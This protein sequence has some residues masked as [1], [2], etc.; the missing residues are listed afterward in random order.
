MIK[1]SNLS[2]HYYNVV[3]L[4]DI[5]L[6]V[7]RGSVL[8]LLGPNGAGKSTLF[9]LIAGFISPDAGTIEPTSGRWGNIGFKPERLLY[10][11]KMRIG[12]FMKMMAGLS[13]IPANRTKQVV[14]EKLAL[15]G[16]ETFKRKRIKDCSKGMRQR[17]GLAQAML[18]DP[19]LL[20]LDEP[21]NGLDPEGQADIQRLMTALKNAGTT[22]LL[23]SHHLP[24]ITQVCTHLV[25]L[26]Q[27]EIQ[28]RNT[29]AK[30]LAE[31]PH[32]AILVDKDPTPMHQFLLRLH[33]DIAI[34]ENVVILNNEAIHLR[35]QVISLLLTAGFDVLKVNQRRTTLAEIY[36]ETMQA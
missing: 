4:N 9:K 7:E 18:G 8:G 14:D 12:G 31:R 36:T 29:M 20:I 34:N 26:K 3:A 28:Y 13:N 25:I 19:E 24:E 15:V 11:P 1:I 5:S 27:G 32:T 21:S 2:K 17:L 22:I 10:P 23:S 16:L 30:A 35:R 6:D 33:P